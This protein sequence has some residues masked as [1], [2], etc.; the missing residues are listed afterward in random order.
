MVL[1][2]RALETHAL[3]LLAHPRAGHCGHSQSGGRQD[4]FPAGLSR[5][6]G[7][8]RAPGHLRRLRQDSHDYGDDHSGLSL[9][10][11]AD[12]L[13]C[14]TRQGRQDA[15][16]FGHEVFSHLHPPG[17]PLRGRLSRPAPTH[18]GQ[19][20]SRWHAGCAHRHDGRDHDGRLF[21]PLFLVQA[22]RPHHLG[23]LVLTGGLR[24]AGGG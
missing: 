16:R 4:T 2:R 9:C 1:R 10:L 8:Q 23:R 22:H 13:C 6:G 11:R 17:F 12:G 20:L 3:L 15:L 18:C 24:R 5:Q 19:G 7:G 21:Q 14:R